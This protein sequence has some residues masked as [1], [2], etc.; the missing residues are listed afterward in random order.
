LAGLITS[1]SAPIRFGV[2]QVNLR[3]GELWKNGAKIKL[4]A[5]PFQILVL[6]LER[7][8]ELVTREELEQKL[9]PSGTFVDFEHSINTA[10][11][12]LREV[13]GDSADS[14]HFIETLPRRGYRFIYPVSGG[15]IVAAIHST[16][17]WWPERWVVVLLG[18]AAV[19]GILLETNFAG[20]RG[21]LLPTSAAPRIESLA[22][23]PLENLTGKPEQKYLVDGIHDELVTQLAQIS[24]LKVISR[25]S[26][27]Q[28][29][30]QKAK[31]L[32]EIAR[33]LGVEAVMEGTVQRAGD[34]IH[35]SVQL[36]RAQDDRHLWAS[37][38]ECDLRDILSL[39]RE[40]A[41]EVAGEVKIQLTPREQAHLAGAHPLNPEA[42]ELYLKGRFLL[43]EWGTD[44]NIR[45]AISYFEDAVQKEPTYAVAH[46]A[47]SFAYL[48]LG[49]AL[50][51]AVPPR[52]VLPKAREAAQKAFELDENSAEAHEVL[53]FI[54]L[55]YDWDWR[56]A[57]RAFRR[58]IELNPNYPPPY[59]WLSQY[60]NV[61][62]RHPDAMV[63]IRKAQQLDPLSPHIE[64]S[65]AESSMLAGALQQS[66][67]QCEKGLDLH[68]EF[69]PL[70]TMLGEIFLR[71]SK[72]D[73]ALA[74][75]EQGV[76]ISKRH[77][78][79]LAV[80]GSAYALSGHRPEAQNILAE[81]KGLS[82]RRYLSPA[83]V[84]RVYASLGDNE[85]A[86]AWLEK[87]YNDRSSW[88]TRIHL[89]GP[90]LGNL[91]A[92]TRFQSLLRRMNLP[93]Q[94]AK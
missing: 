75:L 58:A 57:E 69:W 47:K 72:Y 89:W 26:V 67:E 10:V 12:R 55:A 18:I 19:L 63:F 20:L 50:I 51:E 87:A 45:K 23:L 56:G 3:T 22:V 35:L 53:G 41:R 52:E 29:R 86:L 81:L 27:I 5:Q 33:E 64:W 70:H 30:Q 7:P 59:M 2:F 94:E 49:A 84:A 32:R 91:R 65:L 1:I 92:D 82:R 78:H 38:Y 43:S 28:I 73:R 77:P 14:P 21:R 16:S 40:V 37:S 42:Y 46:A 13:L 68:P 54:D 61:V 11:K 85:Q 17:R 88:M 62:G 79:A 83:N 25:Y 66:A 15:R 74:S 36:I 76:E 90:A 9:W 60:M 6:L 71:Q 8:G 93:Q 31:S 24:A 39:Q 48:E 80:L 34:R 4:E 44:E